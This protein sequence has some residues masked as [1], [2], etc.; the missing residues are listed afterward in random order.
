MG[1]SDIAWLHTVAIQTGDLQ[2]PITMSKIEYETRSN[3]YFEALEQTL[4]LRLVSGPVDK[5]FFYLIRN[6]LSHTSTVHV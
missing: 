4:S 2:M 3:V 5:F 6:S 1:F